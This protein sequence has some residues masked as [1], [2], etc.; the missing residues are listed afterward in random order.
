MLFI[1]EAKGESAGTK[2]YTFKS[3]GNDLVTFALNLDEIRD[4]ESPLVIDP[5]KNL[6]AEF[7]SFCL[8]ELAK[9]KPDYDTISRPWSKGDK[10]GFLLQ[11]SGDEMTYAV[12]FVSPTDMSIVF[13]KEHDSKDRDAVAHEFL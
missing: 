6:G 11:L 5:S 13:E 2:N 1:S 3:K 10:N 4:R 7:T 8:D 9:N 12:E